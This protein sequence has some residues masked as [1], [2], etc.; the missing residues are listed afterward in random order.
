MNTI[1]ICQ[2]RFLQKRF[3]FGNFLVTTMDSSYTSAFRLTFWKTEHISLGHNLLS[4][5][6]LIFGLM[7]LATLY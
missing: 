5:F 6:Y 3:S 4:S 1:I 7:V 2:E